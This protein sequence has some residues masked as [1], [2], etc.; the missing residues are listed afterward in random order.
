MIAQETIDTVRKIRLQIRERL[1]KGETDLR[2]IQFE[3]DLRITELTLINI[4]LNEVDKEI[5]T[6]SRLR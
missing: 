6:I 3:R 5:K 2:L 4:A 1:D